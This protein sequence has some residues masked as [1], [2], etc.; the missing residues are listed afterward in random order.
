M[1]HSLLHRSDFLEEN[2]VAVGDSPLTALLKTV[3][4]LHRVF[5]LTPTEISGRVISV[6]KPTKEFNYLAELVDYTPELKE[7][8]GA[9]SFAR[10]LQL[11]VVLVQTQLHLSI[12]AG[13]IQAVIKIHLED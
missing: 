3:S 4:V 5:N 2:C 13:D 7:A 10:Y 11:F 6:D 9:I 1:A 12:P 8:K